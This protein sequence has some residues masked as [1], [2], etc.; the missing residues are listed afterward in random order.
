MDGNDDD[1]VEMAAVAQAGAAVELDEMK[2][3]LKEMEGE[4]AALRE[5]QVKVENEICAV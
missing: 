2:K 5:M 1:E 3:R 4:V